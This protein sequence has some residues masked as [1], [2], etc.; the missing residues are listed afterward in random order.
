VR[1]GETKCTAYI[2]LEYGHPEIRIQA[3]RASAAS[4]TKTYK[5]GRLTSRLDYA[6][7]KRWIVKFVSNT[8][9]GHA[10]PTKPSVVPAR[11]SKEEKEKYGKEIGLVFANASQIADM[12]FH[13]GLPA[14]SPHQL[15]HL[16]RAYLERC[17]GGTVTVEGQESQTSTFANESSADTLIRML[18]RPGV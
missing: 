17:M 7:A 12:R 1:D 6:A 16:A 13:D 14:V 3:A 18:K 2:I 15:R 9:R 11:L 5:R 4:E 8:H 10:R